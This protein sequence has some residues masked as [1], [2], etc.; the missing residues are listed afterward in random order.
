METAIYLD[1]ISPEE[2]GS[3]RH[4]RKYKNAI[5]KIA[6]SG[7]YDRLVPIIRDILYGKRGEEGTIRIQE[8]DG[9]KTIS[10]LAREVGEKIAYLPVLVMLPMDR[11][12]TK[13]L[14]EQVAF[15]AFE[16]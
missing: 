10:I 1:I 15:G 2:G 7:D 9:L 12:I 6:Q 8:G 11:E 13:N 3:P 16:K 14:F 4:Y 5:E